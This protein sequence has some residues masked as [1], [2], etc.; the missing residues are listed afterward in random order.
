MWL[1]QLDFT[2]KATHL[3]KQL[4]H[5]LVS[6]SVVHIYGSVS[7]IQSSEQ[8]V[9][10]EIIKCLVDFKNRHLTASVPI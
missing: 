5:L 6:V 7:C 9:V 10:A 2:L 8:N 4:C 1:Q 3:V